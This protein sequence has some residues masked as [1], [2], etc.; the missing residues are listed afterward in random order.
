MEKI[1]KY[2][3]IFLLLLLFVPMTQKFIKFHISEPLNGTAAFGNYPSF[4][5]KDWISGK[6]QQLAELFVNDNFGFRNDL[7]RLANSFDYLAFKT[8][9]AGNVVVGKDDYLFFDYNIKGYLGIK[10]Q[11]RNVIDSLFVKTDEM[12]KKLS[13]RNIKLIFVIAPSNAFYYSDKFPPQYDTYPKRE[14][15]YDYY[16]RKLNEYNIPYIDYNKWF[17][18]IK[19]TVSI[20]LFPKHGTHYTYFSAIWVAD[21][22]VKYLEND[23]NIDMPDIITI[24]AKTDSMKT[25]EHDIENVMNLSYPLRND[26]L[27]Y[28]KL[29]FNSE[30][31]TKPKVLAVGDSFYWPVINQLIPANCFSNV[32]YWFYNDKVYP[33]SFKTPTTTDQVNL[34]S[35]FNGLNYIIIY[36]SATLLH[37]YDYDG[38]VGE[39]T[40]Y[41]NGN[42]TKRNQ[43]ERLKFWI[44]AIKDNPEWLSNIKDKATKLNIPLE[45]QIKNEATWMVEHENKNK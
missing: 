35:L 2:C 30:G 34:D 13:K 11:D 16:I 36:T 3:F 18:D 24:S 7:L 33:E 21:S 20:D 37:R 27:Y 8:A 39:M 42:Y 9:N 26:D 4:H 12:C 31:K 43:N 38:F 22:L 17:L 19:D 32:A 44:Q 6:Y 10:T 23:M 40:D 14:N 41:L 25:Y 28:Y 15:D 29:K 1:K 45:T 5:Y